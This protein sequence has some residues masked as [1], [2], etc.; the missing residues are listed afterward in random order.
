M[1]RNFRDNWLSKQTDGKQLIEEYYAIAPKIVEK[2]NNL[3]NAK[4]IYQSIWDN[5]LK[6]CLY[7]LEQKNT[8]SCKEI[9]MDMVNNL[10][11]MYL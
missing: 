2:I 7:Y 9:Y 5:Y 4:E 8:K 6:D 1:F 10:K 3:V 11:K